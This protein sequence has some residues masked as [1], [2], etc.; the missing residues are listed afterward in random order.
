MPMVNSAD[1]RGGHCKVYG[2]YAVS[3]AE[4]AEP[5]EMSFG[6]W[7]CVGPRNSTLYGSAHW[8]HLANMTGTSVCGG[9]A[10]SCQINLTTY[11]KRPTLPNGI[12]RNCV[13]NIKQAILF[14]FIVWFC[15]EINVCKLQ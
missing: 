2:F 11:Q 14:P 12:T 9:D 7:T 13:T 6:M 1:E 3:C 15:D 5:I 10:A 4:T 8:C